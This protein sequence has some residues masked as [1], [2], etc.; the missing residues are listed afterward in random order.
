MKMTW[1]NIAYDQ[2][3]GRW[4][5]PVVGLGGGVSCVPRS[6]RVS[7]IYHPGLLVGF[8]HSN[9]F[10]KLPPFPSFGVKCHGRWT[11]V[12]KLAKRLQRMGKCYLL[13]GKYKLGIISF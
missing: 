5:S 7:I 12:L 13:G 6:V 9:N 2:G 4:T 1:E 11:L 8:A 3:G 10:E